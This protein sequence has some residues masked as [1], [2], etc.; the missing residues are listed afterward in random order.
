M[1]TQEKRLK[2]NKIFIYNDISYIL[3]TNSSELILIDSVDVDYLSNFTWRINDKGYAITTIK[4]KHIRLPYLLFNKREGFDID[5]VNG[6]RTDNRK[7]NLRFVTRGDNTRN[8]ISNN[9]TGER[10][11]YIDKNKP[12]KYKVMLWKNNKHVNIGTFDS[13]E[14][15]I[16]ERDVAIY[17]LRIPIPYCGLQSLVKLNG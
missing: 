1:T 9:K 2:Y 6:N 16:N 17:I 13:M 12:N 8:R 4:R 3:P 11:I 15:A 5:H 7:C 14:Q 10:F